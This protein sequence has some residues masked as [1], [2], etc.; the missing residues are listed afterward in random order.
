M[1]V[2]YDYDCLLLF[3]TRLSPDY[4]EWKQQKKIQLI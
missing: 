3:D 2:I 4:E 1:Y